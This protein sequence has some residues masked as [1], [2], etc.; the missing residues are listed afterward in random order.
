MYMGQEQPIGKFY[1]KSDFALGGSKSKIYKT[2]NPL[3]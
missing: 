2:V 3:S 1:P